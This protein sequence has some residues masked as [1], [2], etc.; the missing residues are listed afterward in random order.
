MKRVLALL[1]AAAAIGTMPAEALSGNLVFRIKSNYAYRVQIEFYAQGRNA[2]WPGS[3]KAYN[4]D[5]SKVHEYSLNC[6]S[7]EK[8]CYGAWVTG[9]QS[10]YWGAGLGGRR[11]CSK[12]CF[13][14]DGGQTPIIT[15]ND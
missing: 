2:A 7:G 9:N 10:K 12:C 11:A 4:L 13:V 1:V 14:C 5:D 3:N 6:H 8:I 15:L